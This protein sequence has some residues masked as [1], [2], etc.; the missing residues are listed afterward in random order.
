MK[1]VFV[2]TSAWYALI[3][4]C[5]PDHGNIL[6][7]LKAH[8]KRLVTTNFIFDET[9]TLIRYRLGWRQAHE[10][11]HLT[12]QG[13]VAQLVRIGPKDERAAWRI[14]SDYEDKTFSFTDCTS[15]VIM[16]RLGIETAVAL[17][18]DFRSFGLTCIPWDG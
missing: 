8:E 3:D 11:G 15:F 1:R 5:D 4:G 9:I 2:D 7:T 12:L 17:D 6:A 16:R 14:F 13:E 18:R 10:F